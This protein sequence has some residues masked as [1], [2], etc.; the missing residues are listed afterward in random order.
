MDQELS[1]G[2]IVET[3]E[4]TQPGRRRHGVSVEERELKN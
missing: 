2:P 1:Q 4:P 3:S